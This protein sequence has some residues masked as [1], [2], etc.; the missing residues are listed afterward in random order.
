MAFQI[1]DFVSIVASMVNHMRGTSTK[2]T[3][4]QQGSV[5]RTLVE[6]PAVEIEELYMQ[7][8][9]GLREA[10]PVATFQ[11]FGFDKYPA[12]YAN[13]FVSV[14]SRFPV[15]DAFDIP[16]G[17]LFTTLD[18][19]AYRSTQLVHWPAGEIIISIPVLSVAAGAGQNAAQGEIVDSD[20]S[21]FGVDF[22]IGNPAITNGKDSES[23]EEREVRF[24]E[25]V[26]SLSRGT[27]FA[28]IYAAKQASVRDSEGSIMERVTRVGFTEIAGYFKIY[29]YSTVGVPSEELIAN[30]Q[31]LLDGTE[32]P[33]TKEI[34]TIGFRSAAIRGD[35]IAMNERPISMTIRARMRTGYNLSND[36]KQS[37]IDTYALAV[38]NIQ[39]GGTLLIDNL[40]AQLLGVKD[41][42]EISLSSSQNITCEQSE[43]LVPG[44]VEVSAL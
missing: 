7:M 8:F 33:D 6:G 16:V 30:G 31:S 40:R 5:A 36:V 29:L 27:K 20:F 19:K 24:S 4:Y 28:C 12:A 41:V 21:E 25:F 35:I 17:T 32:D 42:L 37:L 2:I 14:S 15:V 44:S 1:K 22:T 34:L 13:G 43:A 39:P 3:D 23:D 26:S 9:V 38:R 10:I 18:G 11:S